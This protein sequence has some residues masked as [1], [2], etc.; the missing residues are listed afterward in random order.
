MN[1]QKTW[2]PAL[3]QRVDIQFHQDASGHLRWGGQLSG[4]VALGKVLSFSGDSQP[5]PADC[6][7]PSAHRR[8]AGDLFDVSVESAPLL[9]SLFT[10]RALPVSD[11]LR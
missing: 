5:V 11:T 4:W 2:S 9:P 6:G 8:Y 7:R 3:T 1:P 10:E